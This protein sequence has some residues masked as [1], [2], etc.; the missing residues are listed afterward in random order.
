MSNRT[1]RLSNRKKL[2]SDDG[3]HL[4]TRKSEVEKKEKR[5]ISPNAAH[6][7]KKS[8]FFKITDLYELRF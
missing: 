7:N 1:F 6:E 4:K 3:L 5:K 8:I 2:K